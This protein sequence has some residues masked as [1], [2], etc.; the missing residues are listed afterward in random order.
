MNMTVEEA[1]A[2]VGGAWGDELPDQ[3]D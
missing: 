2:A 1:G 3:D